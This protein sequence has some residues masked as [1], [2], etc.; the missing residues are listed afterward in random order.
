[1]KRLDGLWSQVVAFDNLWL[2]WRRARRGKSRS[3]GAVAFKLDLER[4]LLSLQR[5]LA[6]GDYRPGDYRLFTIYERKP[7]LI[8]AAPFPDRVVHHAVMN[9]IE[10][11]LDRR[12]IAD[13]YACRQGKG[14]HLAVDRYQ[15]WAQ[16]Y[17]YALKLDVRRY[18]PSIDHA[19]LKET[20]RRHLR[21]ERLLALLDLIIDTGP[22]SAPAPPMY[23]LGNGLLTP[24]ERRCGIPI[25]NLTSQFFANLYLNGLDH[26]IKETRQVPAYLR[27]V[28]DL[29][30]LDD[31]KGR[32]LDWRDWIA[33]QL[34]TLRLQLHLDRGKVSQT[35]E[36][37]DLL[38]YHIFPHHRRLRNENGFRF[39]RRLRAFA[40]GYAEG[41]LDWADF[42]P[43]V[44]AW[45][46]HAGHADTL[47][48]REQLFSEVHFQRERA[49][50]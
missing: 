40:R 30:L 48:L 35:R 9:V 4:N 50:G 13:T 16:R 29:V 44:Q 3:A 27:Y 43:S 14:V 25:G 24:L 8:A 23:F 11:P 31:D 33:G 32:L 12:F 42:D 45:I 46:G 15:G 1:M 7:R 37:L 18:F 36:G 39:R 49:E 21:D 26:G 6:N 10:P 28:D 47:G 34:T 20:V 5:D 2:A 22:A 38:G 17:R 41:R 19:I